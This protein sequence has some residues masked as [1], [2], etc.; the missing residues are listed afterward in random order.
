VLC[1]PA[2]IGFVA[3]ATGLPLALGGVA[4]LLGI[5]AALASTVRPAAPWPTVRREPQDAA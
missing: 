1:G 2:A 3:Q 5:V 4:L